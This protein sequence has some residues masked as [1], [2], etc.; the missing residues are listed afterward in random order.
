MEN[1][2]NKLSFTVKFTII[3]SVLAVVFLALSITS[4]VYSVDRTIEAID[5]I[6][7][8]EFS[9]ETKEKIDLAQSYFNKLDTN[10]GLDE[11][12]TNSDDLYAAKVEYVRLGIKRAY[13]AHKDGESEEIIKEYLTDA[14]QSFDEYLAEADSADLSNYA[15]LTD[16]EEKY[17]SGTD[18]SG[19]AP[20]NIAPSGE[21]EEIELC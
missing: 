19:N 17:T 21:G 11:K 6:G 2:T 15:D 18:N 14:R 3:L 13:L 10:I 5:S 4:A 1:S 16:L 9:E 7:E 12:I 8:V 20:V